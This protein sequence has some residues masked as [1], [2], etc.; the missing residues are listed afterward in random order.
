MNLDYLREQHGRVLDL[1]GEHLVLCGWALLVAIVVAL[2]VGTIISRFP[3]TSFPVLGTLDVFYAVPTLA[4]LSFLI[5][6]LPRVSRWIHRLVPFLP[7]TWIALEGLGT[8]PAVIA[9]AAYAQLALVR[10]IATALRGVDPALLEAARGMGMTSPQVLLKVRLPLAAPIL[11]AGVRIAAVSIISLASVTAWVG[12]GGLGTLLFDGIT[13]DYPSMIL[14]G[15]VA[16]VGIA[17][18]VDLLFRLLERLT[19]TSR[20]YQIHRIRPVLAATAEAGP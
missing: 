4:F 3:A 13:R 5:P 15:T 7:D 11:L 8:D 9:L 18:A 12:A 16:I 17:L 2:P 14:A 19:P 6:I 20:A 10:N 1:A